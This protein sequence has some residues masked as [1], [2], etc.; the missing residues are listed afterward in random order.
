MLGL[1]ERATDDDRIR[2]LL[3][4][5]SVELGDAITAADAA[6]GRLREAI[7]RAAAVAAALR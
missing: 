6:L 5:A 3:D 1:Q 4:H 7:T 2:D